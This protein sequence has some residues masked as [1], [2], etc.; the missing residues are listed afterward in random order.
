MNIAHKTKKVKFV[1]VVVYPKMLDSIFTK[2]QKNLKYMK[3]CNVA[4]FLNFFPQEPELFIPKEIFHR[5]PVYKS[6]LVQ[7][8]KEIS[9]VMNALVW[10][11]EGHP[12]LWS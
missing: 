1:Y 6:D 5:T 11:P 10:T 4:M 8:E 9:K 12:E 7:V 3:K 2:A